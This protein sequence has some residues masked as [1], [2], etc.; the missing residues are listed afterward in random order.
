MN[1]GA[2]KFFQIAFIDIL[3]DHSIF[4][5]QCES[6]LQLVSLS[7]QCLA[8]QSELERKRAKDPAHFR[9][10][11]HAVRKLFRDI[12]P[13]KFQRPSFAAS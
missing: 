3:I 4:S 5:A 6:G 1:V 12:L 10:Y 9:I 11:L 2:N 7:Q 8:P 13:R